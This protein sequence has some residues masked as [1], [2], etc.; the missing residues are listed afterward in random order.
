M[1]LRSREHSQTFTADGDLDFIDIRG[2]QEVI[3][4]GGFG[5]GTLTHLPL[6]ND[7]TEGAVEKTITVAESY[8]SEVQSSRFTL[9]GATTPT[10]RVTI[11]P[12]VPTRT[13]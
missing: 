9:T 5:G 2:P 4:T 13:A 12:I 3:I 10:L 6:L 7:L 8:K 11:I 1:A